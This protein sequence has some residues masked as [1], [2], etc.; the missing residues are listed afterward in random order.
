MAFH[1]AFALLASSSH[2]HNISVF[3]THQMVRKE[4]EAHSRLGVK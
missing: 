4:I 1:G 3:L 2:S